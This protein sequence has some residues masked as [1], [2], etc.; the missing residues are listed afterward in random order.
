MPS[1]DDLAI[2]D[3]FNKDFTLD[4]SL[5]TP[6]NK[7]LSIVIER[8]PNREFVGIA[9]F[10]LKTRKFELAM[11][12]RYK[13]EEERL[14][15]KFF[16][17]IPDNNIIDLAFTDIQVR[18]SYE[19]MDC[20]PDAYDVAIAFTYPVVMELGFNVV[21]ETP[22]SLVAQWFYA[23]E[24]EADFRV[25]DDEMRAFKDEMLDTLQQLKRRKLS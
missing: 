20:L 21:C 5:L 18:H 10:D 16:S 23:V 9:C 2:I 17:L 22:E 12:S 8:Y 7:S 13:A 11:R 4:C 19:T 3:A 15:S 24:D 25:T 14:V 1:V 6:D